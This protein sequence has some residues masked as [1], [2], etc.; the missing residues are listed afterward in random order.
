MSE[1]KMAFDL[2]VVG[3]GSGGLRAARRVAERGGRVAVPVGGDLCESRLC[4]EE[5]VL[6]CG[7]VR[8]AGDD[9]G[10]LWLA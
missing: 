5:A 1:G 4:A 6:L 3:G 10:G 2:L 9:G 7:G 8:W